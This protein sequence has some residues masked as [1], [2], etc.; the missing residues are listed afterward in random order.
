MLSIVIPVRNRVEL[1]KRTLDSVLR[2]TYRPLHV[3]LVDNDSTDNTYEV[4]RDWQRLNACKEFTI[5]LATEVKPGAA[6]A[7]NAGLKLVKS[8]WV[9]FFDSD[10]VMTPEHCSR[11][12]SAANH[13]PKAQIVGWPVEMVDLK[14]RSRIRPC[15]NTDALF[16]CVHHGSLATQRYMAK[17]ALVREVGAWRPDVMAWDDIE[18]GARLLST[19]DSRGQFVVLNAVPTV[20]VYNQAES[21]TGTA[22]SAN[23]AKCE[24]ALDCIQASLPNTKWWIVNLKRAILAGQY[25]RE[26][27]KDQGD[28]LMGKI[29]PANRWRAFLYRFAYI[30]TAIGL[31]GAARLMRPC[32][33][34]A[35]P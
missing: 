29:K 24:H 18:L 16:H 6:A 12:M 31:R 8:Q 35:K 11:A 30:Y 13:Y 3:I 2:Q 17:T 19:L 7:R 25:R 21:I 34:K 27:N 14:G 1:V 23:G 26:G 28:A 4:L 10:D 20:T 32:F 5:E 22:F 9:M 33:P 15:E